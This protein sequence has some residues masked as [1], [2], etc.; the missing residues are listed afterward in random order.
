[1][2]KLPDDGSAGPVDY[3]GIWNQRP[4]VRSWHHYD[5]NTASSSARN[6]G[7]TVGVGSLTYSVRVEVTDAIGNWLNNLPS[8]AWPFAPPD[9][10]RVKQGEAVYKAKCAFCHGWLDMVKKNHVNILQS[11]R[12]RT[13]AGEDSWQPYDRTEN[14]ASQYMQRI[15]LKTIG[16]DPERFNVWRE[17]TAD[18]KGCLEKGPAISKED[19]QKLGTA[20]DQKTNE[21]ACRH[22][23]AD[24]ANAAGYLHALWEKTAFRPTTEDQTYLAGP[25]DG[26]WAKAP[27]LHNGSVPTMRDLLRKAA[28]RP[29]KF[30]RG[31]TAYNEKDMGFDTGA[32]TPQE[33]AGLDVNHQG[34]GISVYDTSL[35]GNHNTGHEYAVDLSDSD[36]DALIE[37]LKTL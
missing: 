35:K 14:K 32:L 26:T 31:R 33:E 21:P 29:A 13:G 15:A 9:D 22:N 34:G 10:S 17:N 24:E 25:L 30:V 27:Y 4:T 23:P 20:R 37:Y 12:V 3:P 5:G 16:T 2:A 28:D 11:V 36:K 19:L 7:S 1:V 18:E 8:P 6:R